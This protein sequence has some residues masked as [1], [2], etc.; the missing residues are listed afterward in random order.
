[1]YTVIRRYTAAA[2]LIEEMGRKSED[3]ERLIG[4][5][6]GFVAYQAVRADDTLVTVTVCRDR[7]GSEETTRRAAEWVRDNIPPGAMGA[8]EVT[9]GEAFLEF[10]A[11]QTLGTG[12]VRA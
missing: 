2:P 5:V 1:M 12:A 3:V 6:P 11:P 4:S 10:A 8:P 9:E 7:A